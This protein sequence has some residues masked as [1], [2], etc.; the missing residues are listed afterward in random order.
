M[1][2]PTSITALIT[3]EPLSLPV[4][5]RDPLWLGAG[6]GLGEGEL[7]PDPPPWTK[8]GFTDSRSDV[9]IVISG[10][11][12]WPTQFA[13]PELNAHERLNSIWGKEA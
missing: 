13:R 5:A 4:L 3:E 8:N 1:N 9:V 12:I 11:S 6:V 7:P 10:C 2:A